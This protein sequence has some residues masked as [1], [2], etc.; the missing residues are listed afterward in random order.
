MWQGKGR[1]GGVWQGLKAHKAKDVGEGRWVCGG[2]GVIEGSN[3]WFDHLYCP[4]AS[5]TVGSGA[6]AVTPASLSEFFS[7]I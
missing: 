6:G 1:R 4:G 3:I 7:F 5:P 2:E